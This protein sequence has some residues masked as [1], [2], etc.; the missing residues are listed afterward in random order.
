MIALLVATLALLV[1]GSIQPGGAVVAAAGAGGAGFAADAGERAGAAAERGKGK[2]RPGCRKFCQQAGGFGDGGEDPSQPVDLPE[3]RIGGARDRIVAVKATCRLDS[4]CVGAII[5][6]GRH[7]Y[8]YGRADLRIPAQTTRK[9]K[10]GI[11][12]KGLAALKKKGDDRG[13]FVTVPL[14]DPTQPVSFSKRITLLAP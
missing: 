9:V 11:S 1:P 13:A 5:L 3:Q 6:N 7:V 4:E 8:E 10:V 12:R 2:K 14:V